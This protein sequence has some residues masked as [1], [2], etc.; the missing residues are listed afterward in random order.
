MASDLW[1]EAG[2]ILSYLA[3][4]REVDTEPVNTEALGSGR[5]LALPR[6][7]GEALS[8]RTVGSL[9]GPWEQS[10]YRIREP[11]KD[12]PRLALDALLASGT[13]ILLLVPGLAF[14]R[15]GGRLGRGKGFYDRFLASAD[16]SRAADARV[17][18][19]PSAPATLI[20]IG[21]CFSDQLVPAVPTGALDRRVDLLVT[22]EGMMPPSTRAAASRGSDQ[23]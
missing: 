7:E 13:A 4:P 14:D 9:D 15:E 11:G 23:E 5:L 20:S 21:L 12:R 16:W 18:E 2:A 1:H 8:F 3:L 22:E 10:G 6:I 17:A 19:A